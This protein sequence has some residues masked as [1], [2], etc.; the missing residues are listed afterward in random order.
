VLKAIPYGRRGF[1]NKLDRLSAILVHLQSKKTVTAKELSQRFDICIR[2]VYRDIRS[3]EAAGIPIGSEPGI[4]YFLVEGYHL[5]PVKFTT[6]EAGALLLAGKLTGAFADA[7][8]KKS[9]D[10][11]LYKIK[12]VLN[13][14]DK[15]FVS[16]IENKVGVYETEKNPPIESNFIKDIQMALYTQSVIEIQYYSPSEKQTTLRTIEPVSLGFYEN[17]WHLV[18]YCRMRNAYRDFRVDRIEKLSIVDQSFQKAH[19]P[20][21][22]IIRKMYESKNLCKVA[23]RLKKD[24]NYEILKKKCELGFLTEKDLGYRVEITLLADSLPILGRWLFNYGS[25]VE[26]LYPIEL[27]TIIK[28]H[29]KEIAQQ[30][31]HMD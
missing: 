19:P 28:Q 23:I 8:T 30:Y 2:T 3:L 14:E 7:K 24:S 10:S 15:V 17:N 11:A 25:D 1:M 12:A 21:E 6:E 20:I 22:I 18:A 16:E 5:P 9:F 4:G 27:K 29:A 31:L 26:I 13:N